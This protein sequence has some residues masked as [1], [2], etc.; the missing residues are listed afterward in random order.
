M[1]HVTRTIETYDQIA[2][3]YHLVSTPE[4]RAWLED[5]MREFYSRLPG[6]TVLVAGCGEGRDSRYL[7]TLGA[8][9]VSLDLSEG[10]L[11]LA[12]ASD[13][14]GSYLHLDLRHTQAIEQKFDGIW[15]CA[16]LYHLTKAEFRLC[17]RELHRILNPDGVLFLNLKLGTG[18]Q[19]IEIPRDGYPGGELA[20]MKIRGNRFFAFYTRDELSGISRIIRSKRSGVI[21]SR[22]ATVRWNFG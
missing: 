11:S 22:K 4:N 17:L 10:M 7:Q 20:K 2:P 21:I 12:R 5:S 14:T 13:P 9:V 3:D 15:A 19:F 16:C 8:Y 18:E 6:K 1:D